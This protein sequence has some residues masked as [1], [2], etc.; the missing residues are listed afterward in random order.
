MIKDEFKFLN[1]LSEI[2]NNTGV[3]FLHSAACPGSHCPMHMAL[4]TIRSMKGV[5]SL[6][7]G[8]PECGY[9]SRFVAVTPFGQSGELHYVYELDSNE[10]VFGCRKGVKNALLQMSEEGA[11]VIVIILTCVPSLIGEDMESVIEEL[12]SEMETKVVFI[13]GAHFKRNGYQSGLSKTLVQLV[14]L[15]DPKDSTLNNNKI[16]ILGLARGKE[17][18]DLKAV[19]T[20]NGFVIEEFYPG[21]GMDRINNLAKARVNLVIN[22]KM[23]KTA[24][25]LYQR[26]NIPY[27]SMAGCYTVSDITKSYEELFEVLQIKIPEDSIKGRT[28]LV[29]CLKCASRLKNK[30]FISTYPELDTLA[31]TLF[32]SSSGMIPELLH[33]EEYD[34]NS[35]VYKKAINEIGVDP[36]I[37]YISDNDRVK[38]VFTE[39]ST[40]LSLGF[41][42][43]IPLERI[44]DNN[45]LR[46]ICTLFGYER[47]QKLLSLIKDKLDWE[48]KKYGTI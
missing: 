10:V 45:T 27:I 6:V 12:E 17:Y 4:A 28:A 23:L 2:N 35:D 15:I 11:K 25:R 46:G 14:G 44:I 22:S 37:T 29:E 31:V 36:L 16:N 19:I 48:G 26:Y 18:E 38:D 1:R 33:V 21:I 47:S 30:S 41:C 40:Y 34:E 20:G 32:L 24:Q 8:M 39:E 3:K 43:G 13:D 7:V 5:S 42:K 9:Y